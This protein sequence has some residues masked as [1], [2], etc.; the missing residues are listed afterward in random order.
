MSNELRFPSITI[1]LPGTFY[2]SDEFKFDP[3]AAT[4]KYLLP[5]D[6][7]ASL[8]IQETVK[9]AGRPVTLVGR[10]TVGLIK[11][12]QVLA[13]DSPDVDVALMGR[14][15]MSC[16]FDRSKGP[17]IEA[18][19]DVNYGDIQDTDWCWVTIRFVEI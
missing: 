17:A 10:A 3:I 12:L 19:R 4:H 8:L 14:E 7:E 5:V 2:W 1:P 18:D 6:G 16:M 9:T 15:V 11:Q 13:K